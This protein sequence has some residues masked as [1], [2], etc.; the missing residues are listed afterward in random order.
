MI[1]H[2]KRIVFALLLWSLVLLLHT[3]NMPHETQTS[4][5]QNLADLKRLRNEYKS[6]P[7]VLVTTNKISAV[8]KHMEILPTYVIEYPYN[9]TCEFEYLAA[10]NVNKTHSY[11]I[12]LYY[13]VGMIGNWRNIV[14]DQLDTLERCGL[15]YMATKFTISVNTE[16]PDNAYEELGLIL[17]KYH[18]THLLVSIR[19]LRSTFP[20]TG[21]WSIMQD[22]RNYCHLNINSTEHVE[23]IYY[24]HTK[25]VGRYTTNWTTTEDDMYFKMLSWRKYMEFFHLERPTLCLR[26]FLYHGASVCGVN[27][28]GDPS[29]H[30]SGNFWSTTCNWITLLNNTKPDGSDL[31][32]YVGA[33]IWIGNQHTGAKLLPIPNGT[34]IWDPKTINITKYLT[35]HR[36]PAYH[37]YA[38]TIRTYEYQ[39]VVTDTSY[40]V[41]NHAPILP[42]Y[43]NG[44]T[45]MAKET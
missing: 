22:M 19:Y 10:P 21:E 2:L 6:V 30:F 23:I 17:Q 41:G 7:P 3:I 16:A 12:S 29:F 33:E 45:S 38:R 26:A 36:H 39:H 20:K 9:K 31:L 5:F 35:L 1:L 32:L 37:G 44:L 27:S 11:S 4:L 34:L 13:H 18:F 28:Q 42:D 24:F 8:K 15:G 40:W 25:G 14:H 43:L